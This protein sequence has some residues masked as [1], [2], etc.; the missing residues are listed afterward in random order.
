M[1]EK[2]SILSPFKEVGGVKQE[3]EE[4]EKKKKEE[5]E[6]GGRIGEEGGR[7]YWR[8]RGAKMRINWKLRRKRRKRGKVEEGKEKE[9]EE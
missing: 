8:R 7:R 1:C 3:D 2:L 6:D 5:E 4:K 9:V